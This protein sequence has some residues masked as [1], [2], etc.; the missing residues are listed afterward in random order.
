[1]ALTWQTHLLALACGEYPVHLGGGVLVTMG[2][3]S[4]TNSAKGLHETLELG[5]LFRTRAI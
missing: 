3:K 5:F 4:R 2:L 1:M